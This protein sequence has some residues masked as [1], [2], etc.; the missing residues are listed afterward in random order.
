MDLT[1][2]QTEEKLELTQNNETMKTENDC[3]KTKDFWYDL[4]EELIAQEPM[5][6]RDECRLLVADRENSQITHKHFSDIIDYLD[7]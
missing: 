2:S 1:L 3:F 5:K 4:P 7:E 6:V